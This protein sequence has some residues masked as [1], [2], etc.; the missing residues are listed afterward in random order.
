MSRSKQKESRKNYPLRL[1]PSERQILQIKADEANL[2]L[3]EYLRVAGLNATISSPAKMPEINRATYI[4]LG[5]I[6]NNIN[7]IAKTIY[8]YQQRGITFDE[9]C[10]EL[11]AELEKLKSQ[12]QKIRLETIGIASTSNDDC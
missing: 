12:L 6:G 3:S 8:S 5:Q 2:K 11:Q 7:Q 9:I 10:I 1:S 4:E